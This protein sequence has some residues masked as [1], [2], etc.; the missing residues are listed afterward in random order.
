MRYPPFQEF[1]LHDR[2]RKYPRRIIDRARAASER[3]LAD[4]VAS[5]EQARG[6]A[7]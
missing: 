2:Y 3:R 4:L 5:S 1:I 7:W 6:M